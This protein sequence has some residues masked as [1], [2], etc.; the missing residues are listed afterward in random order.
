MNTE[1]EAT[2]SVHQHQHAPWLPI[3]SR[4]ISAVEHPCIVKNV[5]KGITSLGGPAKLSKGLRSRIDAANEGEEV[6]HLKQ[7][8]SVSLRPDDPFAKRLLST[9]VTTNNLLLKVTV[10][11]RTG[12]KRK[13]GSAGPFCTEDELDQSTG[14]ARGTNPPTNRV[15]TDAST[16]FKSLQDN[17][18]TY[19]VSLAGVVDETHRFR[20]M[21]DLQY[22]AQHDDIMT[23]LRD[24]I[25]PARYDEIK[26]YKIDT[27]PGANMTKSIGPS[28]EFMQMPI[29]FNYR[30]QQNSY[31]KYTEQ[32][33]VNL[34][35]RLAY[36]SYT[37]IKPTDP[38]VPTG[39]KPNLPPESSLTPYLQTLIAQI[40]AELKKRPIITRH[41]LYNRLGWDRRNRLRQAAIY[42]GYFFESGPWREALVQW[43]VDPRLD[44][45]YR[46][47]QTV[48]FMSYLKTGRAKHGKA[49]DEH[50]QKLSQMSSSELETQHIFDG[51]SVSDTGNL[52][53]FCDLTDPLLAKVVAT[54]DIRTTCAPTFQGWYHV[55]TWAKITVILKDKMNTLIAGE[56]LDDDRYARVV[57]WPE[58]W[59]DQAILAT[60]KTE[61]HDRQIRQE[62]RK[63]HDVMNNVRWAARSPRY[64]FE[65]M[66]VADKQRRQSPA[67]EEGE[68][69]DDE[70]I[71]EDMTEVPDTAADILDEGEK[72]GEDQEF[73]NEDDE[74]LDTQLVEDDLGEQRGY[75][76]RE[77]EDEDEDDD[78]DVPPMSVR[79]IS[80]GPAPFG[81]LYRV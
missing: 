62:K 69:I 26:N 32:G 36:N 9:A 29:A 59:D 10:P 43:G 18:S 81:G 37:I 54:E 68:N 60:Y 46:K 48:S 64:A 55:G 58:L 40:R 79:V 41:L 38:S 42:C 12:R 15:H 23:G 70:E 22:A 39:P 7:L 72:D 52:F 6:D 31:V 77:D 34:Q 78:S 66:E 14:T 33:V 8:I 51:R 35:R 67:E 44:P 4:A 50:V 49:F 75:E 74:E 45:M 57:A 80:E 25:L 27:T 19:K 56:P 71:P 1:I 30:F 5:D 53:Q 47:Y 3:P 16:I 17:A 24:H 63:E 2:I 28:A 20:T 76:G 11:K 13:R 21:P 61:I 65:K 73:D